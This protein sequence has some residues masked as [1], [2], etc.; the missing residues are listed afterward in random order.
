M[1]KY[2]CWEWWRELV[3]KSLPGLPWTNDPRE[4][5]LFWG[6]APPDD[7]KIPDCFPGAPTFESVL[8]ESNFH[9]FVKIKPFKFL[10]PKIPYSLNISS[11]FFPGAS[12]GL[13]DLNQFMYRNWT[14]NFHLELG[15]ADTAFFQKNEYFHWMNNQKNFWMNIFF[16]WML[17]FFWMNFFLN[18]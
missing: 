10:N 1:D 14:E 8:Q 17:S 4:S 7:P 11:D 9:S 3:V 13:Q 15:V 2:K 18:E 16:E 5:R 6:D 12:I